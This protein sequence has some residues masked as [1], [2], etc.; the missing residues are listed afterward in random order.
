MSYDFQRRRQIMTLGGVY[1]AKNLN[2]CC[3]Q[4]VTSNNT[5]I[6]SFFSLPGPLLA[7]PKPQQH[8][9]AGPGPSLGE[10]LWI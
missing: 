3:Q 10:Q 5:K 9:S 6:K 7:H 4:G 8:T 1:T 2:L